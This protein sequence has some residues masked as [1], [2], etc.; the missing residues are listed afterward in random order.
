M[1]GQAPVGAR[2]MRIGTSKVRSSLTS[3]GF[4]P[5]CGRR[6]GYWLGRFGDDRIRGDDDGDGASERL[7]L[8]DDPGGERR[9]TG[10]IEEA[11]ADPDP[12]E[13]VRVIA[14]EQATPGHGAHLVIELRPADTAAPIAEPD[15]FD[16]VRIR[17]S[18]GGATWIHRWHASLLV[19]SA[20]GH[21]TRRSSAK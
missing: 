20:R 11:E 10:H 2:T 17:R 3:G 13:V 4:G 21:A 5:G 16:G 15:E 14:A 8:A 9:Q 6:Q 7:F 1:R 12:G 19:R 18:R